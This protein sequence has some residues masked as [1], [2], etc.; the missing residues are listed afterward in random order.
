MT[1]QGLL[2]S[3]ML[4]L[5]LSGIAHA[6]DQGTTLNPAE[7]CND[8]SPCTA[9]MKAVITSYTQ[10][11]LQFTQKLP[12]G[13]SGACYHQDPSYDANTTHYGAFAFTPQN[14]QIMASGLFFFFY[15]QDPYQ[16]LS[17]EQMLQRMQQGGSQLTATLQ[18][19]DHL[20]L[21]FGPSVRYWFR[22]DKSSGALA[23]IGQEQSGGSVT[24]VFCTMTPH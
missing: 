13:F 19:S 8:S 17:L 20:E 24:R 14:S 2:L 11:S 9:N 22:S 3:V 5:G 15:A 23:V 18:T 10:G 16:G 21:S 12:R 1:K 4:T 6:Q 7:L